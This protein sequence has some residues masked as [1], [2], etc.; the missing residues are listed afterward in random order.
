[1]GRHKK[2]THQSNFKKTKDTTCK[3]CEQNFS[4]PSS[5]VNKKAVHDKTN[6][7]SCDKS[8]YATVQKC[9]VALDEKVAHEKNKAHK[10]NQCN[11]LSASP[12][13]LRQHKKVVHN[14]AKDYKC[15]KCK[16]RSGWDSRL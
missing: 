16:F 8:A 4:A 14:K 2:N 9:N 15:D 12:W 3:P 7:Q 10:C 1:M 11:Y 5:R 6:D 13:Y